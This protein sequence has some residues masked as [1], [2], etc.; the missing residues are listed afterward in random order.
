MIL[1]ATGHA[2]L[3]TLYA[4]ASSDER[5]LHTV[6]EGVTVGETYFSAMRRSSPR[7]GKAFFPT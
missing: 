2:S 3:E 5:V 7:C 4:A 1:P 6:I